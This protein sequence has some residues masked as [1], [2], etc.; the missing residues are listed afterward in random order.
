MTIYR[1][2]NYLVV[3]CVEKLIVR[4]TVVCFNGDGSH[5][6][7]EGYTPLKIN[8]YPFIVAFS[9]SSVKY[10][11]KPPRNISGYITSHGTYSN[12]VEH[13]YVHVDGGLVLGVNPSEAG[14]F[15]LN[16]KKLIV[17]NETILMGGR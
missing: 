17:V 16:I 12:P 13:P 1:E 10:H 6:I 4:V 7:V 8:Y 2:N 15:T 3:D 9:G 5:F 11:G 14:Y